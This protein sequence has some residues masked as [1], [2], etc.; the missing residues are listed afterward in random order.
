MLHMSGFPRK[1][2]AVKVK[3]GFLYLNDAKLT[4]YEVLARL[5]S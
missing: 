4:N 2:E 1:S 3:D 5:G